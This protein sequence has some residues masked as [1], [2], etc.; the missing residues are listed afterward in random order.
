MYIAED[1]VIEFDGIPNEA[2]EPLNEPAR[3]RMTAYIKANGGKTPRV[4]DVMYAHMQNRPKDG[5]VILP[6]AVHNVP[7]Q[8]HLAKPSVPG[9]K[10]LPDQ[11]VAPVKKIMGTIKEGTPLGDH[12]L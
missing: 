2:M 3:A 10:I 5:E 6:N 7:Q 4:E 8:G 12:S 11:S 9:A 1:T